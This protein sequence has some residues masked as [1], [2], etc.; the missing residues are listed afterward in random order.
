MA[1]LLAMR[2]PLFLLNIA[3]LLFG[4]T[5]SENPRRSPMPLR[6]ISLAGAEFGTE[7]NDFSC[8]NPGVEGKDY[9]WNSPETYAWFANQGVRLFRIPFRWERLQPRLGEPLDP[10]ELGHLRQAVDHA[11]AHG[12][13]AL[14]DLHNYGR[15]VFGGEGGPFTAR[16]GD[17]NAKHIL[18]EEDLVDF[19]L[20]ISK[21]FQ[22]ETGIWGYGLMNEPHDL[23]SG[24]WKS[25]SRAVVHA[26]RE[27]S[28]NTLV[29]VGGD[30]W[31]K[32]ESWLEVNGQH[33][34]IN[35]PAW[36]VQNYGPWIQNPSCRIP[37]GGLSMLDPAS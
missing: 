28:D 12:A 36:W 26:L 5:T 6:A 32:S 20:Q 17:L 8:D 31:S 37:H 25:A 24:A 35:D 22:H 2:A 18:S 27:A 33:A 9:V 19:W 30:Q 29:F 10:T 13:T 11:K 23:P 34:W 4:C 16:L 15:Y 7:T 21:E 1:K 3:L 14:L